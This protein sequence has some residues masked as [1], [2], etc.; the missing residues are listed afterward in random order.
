MEDDQNYRLIGGDEPKNNDE[1]TDKETA[2][3]LND[4]STTN[5]QNQIRNSNRTE[6]NTSSAINLINNIVNSFD[7]NNFIS[8][9]VIAALLF[10]PIVN[11]IIKDNPTVKKMYTKHQRKIIK[12]S[13]I[14]FMLFCL[15]GFS[16]TSAPGD[17][18][19]I[20]F[21]LKFLLIIFLLIHSNIF[22]FTDF[23][24]TIKF[25]NKILNKKNK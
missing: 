3:L 16:T 12:Q 19:F 22:N 21:I 8:K 20:S 7:N 14:I 2:F 6:C 17:S 23:N 9:L 11:L 4:C 1:P 25:W 10:H 13:L 5:S 15:I 24:Q 18:S